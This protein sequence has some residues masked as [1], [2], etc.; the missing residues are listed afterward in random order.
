MAGRKP[1]PVFVFSLKGE[2][3]EVFFSVRE[4]SDKFEA[5]KSSIIHA[6]ERE[7]VFREWFYL[8]YN[9]GFTPPDYTIKT[10][11]TKEEILLKTFL[12]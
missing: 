3:Q 2:L 11:K 10:P 8:S 12:V 5:P 4:C 6:I 7:Y 9:V 1:K